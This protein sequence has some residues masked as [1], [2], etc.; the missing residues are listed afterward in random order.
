MPTK[1]KKLRNAPKT[2]GKAK[3]AAG[4]LPKPGTRDRILDVAEL[5]FSTRG[6]DA[7]SLRMISEANNINLG[8]IHYYFGSKEGLFSAVFLRRS[9]T[10]VNR[11]LAMLEKTKRRYGNEPIP[12]EEIIRC[13]I[14]PPVEMMKEGEGPRAYIR[15]QG[16]LR[17]HAF[18]F[19]HKLRGEAFND[20]NRKFIRE[21]RKTCPH[22]APASIVWRFAAM[23]GAYY[24][25]ISQSARVAELS[26]GLCD[27]GDIDAAIAEVIPFVAAGFEAPAAFD[28]ANTKAGNGRYKARR[29]NR[30]I[31][32]PGM[33]T[34]N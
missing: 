26:D 24:S 32:Q 33:E 12:V 21:L 5:E 9:E 13:F 10:L 15:L 23:V 20:T 29:A 25:L 19:S 14:T 31:D 11:R 27:P 18:E 30:R 16:L 3:S 28:G 17:S 4:S 1:R 34:K 7:T 6:Y 8:L 22:L 2:S